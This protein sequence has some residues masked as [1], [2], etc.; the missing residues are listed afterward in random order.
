MS[1]W[2]LDSELV[3]SYEYTMTLQGSHMNK[4]LLLRYICRKINT[5]N[6]WVSN[7]IWGDTVLYLVSYA[8]LYNYNSLMRKP[9]P[10]QIS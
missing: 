4:D 3:S 8:S 1:T 6:N 9:Y 7:Q 10:Q 2:F 5:D